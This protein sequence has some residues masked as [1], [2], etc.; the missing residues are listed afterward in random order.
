MGFWV[1]ICGCCRVCWF[2]LLSRSGIAVLVF[3]LHVGMRGVACLWRFAARGFVACADFLNF[4]L[5]GLSWY[6][7]CGFWVLGCVAEGLVG[8]IVGFAVLICAD[9]GFGGGV[10]HGWVFAVCCLFGGVWFL[11]FCLWA[12]LSLWL[13]WFKWLLRFKWLLAFF[14]LVGGCGFSCAF[15]LAWV[16]GMVYSVLW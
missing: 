15:E 2:D 13:L 6:T 4:W 1:F 7:F 12:G 8:F 11:G 9:L 5:P 16:G 14:G 10:Y 3:V